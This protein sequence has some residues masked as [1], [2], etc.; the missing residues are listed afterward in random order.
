MATIACLVAGTARAHE[1]RVATGNTRHH[2]DAARRADPEGLQLLVPSPPGRPSATHRLPRSGD[3]AWP[4]GQA[5]APRGLAVSASAAGPPV[6]EGRRRTP[7]CPC[8][9]GDFLFGGRPA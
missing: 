7:A 5:P 1:R 9:A 3:E 8:P 6:A 4:R 2:P